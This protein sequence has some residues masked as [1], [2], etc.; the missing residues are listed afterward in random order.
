MSGRKSMLHIY[1]NDSVYLC[2]DTSHAS[3]CPTADGFVSVGGQAGAATVQTLLGT[4]GGSDDLYTPNLASPVSGR[5]VGTR[6][7]WFGVHGDFT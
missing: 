5:Q 2:G 3:G 4:L 6:W 1:L 7:R